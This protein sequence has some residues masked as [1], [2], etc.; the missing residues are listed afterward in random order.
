MLLCIH[1]PSRKGWL[2]Q[3]EVDRGGVH[4]TQYIEYMYSMY[5]NCACRAALKRGAKGGGGW[6]ESRSIY[7]LLTAYCTPQNIYNLSCLT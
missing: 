7:T 6:S 5:S 4:T 2:S 1:T 3:T